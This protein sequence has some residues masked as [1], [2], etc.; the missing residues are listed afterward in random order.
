MMRIALCALAFLSGAA[1][2]VSAS[3]P[4]DTARV[5]FVCEH[6]TVKS[7]VAMEYFNRRAQERGLTY[8]A[9]ARGTAPGLSVPSPVRD[10][11]LADGFDVSTFQPR[12]FEESDVDHASLIVSFDQ[13]VARI[14]GTE[15]RYLKW[16]DLPGVLTDFARGCDEIVRRVDELIDELARC[17]AP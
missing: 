15:V 4:R 3:N 16:D 1:P 5:V 7:L 13:D 12:K 8:R 14:A 10:G 6:G 2:S 11:L 17:N 9:V